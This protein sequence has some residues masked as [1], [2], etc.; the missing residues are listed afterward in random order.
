VIDVGHCRSN[1]LGFSREVADRFT[2]LWEQA[3]GMTYHP[4]ADVVTIIGFLGD[5]RLDR[6]SEGD[7]IEQVL[8]EAVA[9]LS[10]EA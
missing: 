7:V 9:Q 8:T 3:S 5:L 10:G 6:G 4:W 2:H 1:L